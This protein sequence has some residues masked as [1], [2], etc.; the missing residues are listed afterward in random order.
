MTK[1]Y[2]IL[3]RE[4]RVAQG[5]SQKDL[6]KGLDLSQSMVSSIERGEREPSV[7][8]I[9]KINE[10]HKLIQNTT[11]GKK[12]EVTTKHSIMIDDSYALSEVV[13]LIDKMYEKENAS[14]ET[15]LELI[16]QQ[17]STISVLASALADIK[18]VHEE[19]TPKDNTNKNDNIEGVHGARRIRNLIPDDA[20]H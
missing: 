19:K 15:C 8:V 1:D 18:S 11:S 17:Q 9:H 10:L 16:K 12:A 3:L 6:A 13:K 4:I 2:K 7:S 20:P 5:W 14:R